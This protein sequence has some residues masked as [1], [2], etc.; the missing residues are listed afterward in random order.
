MNQR[1]LV[2]KAF[3]DAGLLD[4]EDPRVQEVVEH[5]RSNPDRCWT[6]FVSD[7]RE[8]YYDTFDTVIGALEDSNDPMIRNSL[9]KFADAKQ[10]KEQQLLTK[11]ANEADF[12]QDEVAAKRLGQHKVSQID[13]VLKRRV[14]AKESSSGGRG[15]ATRSNPNTSTR[16]RTRRRLM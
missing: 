11:I 5:V 8:D 9:I 16:T 7:F 13:A 6:D 1:R 3:K 15:R 14:S 10:P 2:W 12:E 4:S